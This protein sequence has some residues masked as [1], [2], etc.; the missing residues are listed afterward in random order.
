[1]I[2]GNKRPPTAPASFI[3][4]PAAV[5]PACP[6][7]LISKTP[8]P[9]LLSAFTL[10]ELLV[11]ISIIAILAA[12]LL[13]ALVKAKASAQNAACRNNLRQIA[14]GLNLYAADYSC[15]VPAWAYPHPDNGGKTILWFDF[16]QPYVV[17]G[18]PSVNWSASGTAIPQ[19]GT[20]VCPAMIAWAEFIATAREHLPTFRLMAESSG[21]TATILMALILHRTH[22]PWPPWAWEDSIRHV[23]NLWP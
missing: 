19:T 18:W 7:V 21:L 11:V 13:P 3:D 5:L 4:A 14:L 17:A 8:P 6:P 12:L 9:T 10:I 1:M 2:H 16:L 23:P 15:F 20:Y 22:P